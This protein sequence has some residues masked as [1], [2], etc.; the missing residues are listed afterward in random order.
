MHYLSGKLTLPAGYKEQ[1]SLTLLQRLQDAIDSAQ[2]RDDDLA[3]YDDLLEGVEMRGLPLPWDGACNLVGLLA[4]EQ[5]LTLH[6]NL[7]EGMYQ[8]TLVEINASTFADTEKAHKAETFLTDRWRKEG[9]HYQ[10]GVHFLSNLLRDNAAVMYGGWSEQVK[11]QQGER[12][13]EFDPQT[14]WFANWNEEAGE[15]DD[16]LESEDRDP[17]KEYVSVPV[18]YDEKEQGAEYRVVDQA[19]FYLYPANAPSVEAALLA[20]ERMLLTEDDLLSGIKRYGYDKGDVMELIA[21]GPTHSGVSES[22]RARIPSPDGTGIDKQSRMD[23]LAGVS[24]AVTNS[25]GGV[26]ECFLCFGRMPKEWKADGESWLPERHWET[27][28][29]FMMCPAHQ[30][31]F[32]WKPCPYPWK[33]YTMQSL[34]P[35]NGRAYGSGQMQIVESSAR[36]ETHWLR[37]TLNSAE[38]ELTPER[39]M[40]EETAERNKNKEIYPGKIWKAETPGDIWPVVKSQSSLLGMTPIQDIRNRINTLWAA[41]GAGELQSKQRKNV[42]V[43]NAMQRADSKAK[44]FLFTATHPLVELAK[45]RIEMELLF[46]PDYA[47]QVNTG[48]G[49]VEITGDDLRGSFTFSVSMLDIDSSPQAQEIRNQ[50]I[51]SIQSGYLDRL[52]AMPQYGEYLWNGARRALLDLKVRKPEEIIGPKPEA[53]P[54]VPM[55]APPMGMD[56]GAGGGMIPGMPPVGAAPMGAGMPAMNGNGGGMGIPL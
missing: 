54:P 13:A 29:V 16:L 17:E 49:E 40:T 39:A 30:S 34:L 23:A 2:D 37:L 50:A 55:I 22:F 26:Y 35:K 44:F 45:R 7:A 53:P 11:R 19:D 46:N 33:P 38:M 41:Q 9:L 47:G 56:A 42:E 28:C 27:E 1:A 21:L 12:Y 32:M 31:I 14:Q 51:L 36:E 6:A 15:P 52:L 20:G 8:E 3:D 24:G 25:E 48:E 43:Q 18:R 10:Y 4:R 5:H